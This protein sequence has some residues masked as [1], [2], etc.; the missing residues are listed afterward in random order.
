M[1]TREARDRMQARVKA[2]FDKYRTLAELPVA[3][4]QGNIEQVVFDEQQATYVQAL[5]EVAALGEIIGRRG[6]AIVGVRD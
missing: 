2:T 4:K 1:K 5:H 6:H 3:K